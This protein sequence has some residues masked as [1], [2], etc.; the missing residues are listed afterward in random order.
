MKQILM[1]LALLYAV[2]QGAWAQGVNYIYYTVNSDGKTI[3]K[4][5][6][7][8]A[9]NPTVLTSKLISDNTEDRLYDGWY[10]L[11]S[12]F[13]Y[14]ERIVIYGDVKLILKDGCTLTAEQGIRINT[15]AKLTI[16]A[17]SEGDNMGKLVAIE[18]HHDK[19]AIGGN[20][21]YEAGRLVI[22]GG[23]IEATCIKESSKYAAGIGGGYGDGSGMKEITIYG[24]KVTAQGAEGGAGIGGGK[25]N[26]HPGT[27]NIYGGDITAEAGD[28]GAGIG[29]G[30]NRDGWPIIINGGKVYAHSGN[31]GAGIG[32]GF[33][34]SGTSVVING[35]WVQAYG[36][37]G[38]AG[39]GGG[40]GQYYSV[41]DDI[42]YVVSIGFYTNATQKGGHSGAIAIHGG[43]VFAE[44]NNYDWTVSA[45]IGGGIWGDV[46]G[47]ITIDGGEVRVTSKTYEG[48][49]TPAIGAGLNGNCHGDITITGTANVFLYS[50]EENGDE[51][52]APHYLIGLSNYRDKAFDGTLNLSGMRVTRAT[53][54]REEKIVAA[55][56]VSVCKD[57]KSLWMRIMPCDH[58]DL[59]Y[60]YINESGHTAHCKYCEYT[61]N[62][63]HS[64]LAPSTTCEKCGYGEGSTICTLSFP[65]TS[66]A[67]VSG[68][69]TA[70]FQAVQGQIITIPACT[71]VPEGWKFVGWLKQSTAPTSIEAADSETTL[72]QPGD[73]YTVT[74]NEMFF[75]RYR[76]DFVETWMWNES[77]SS[78]SLSI[79]AGS[80]EAISVTPVTVSDRTEIAATDAA[81]GSITATATATYTHGSTTYTFSSTQT[82]VL[83]YSLSLGEDDNTEALTT[84]KGRSMNVTLTG[85]TLYKDGNWNTLCLPFSVGDGDDTDDVTFSGSPLAGA[86]VKELTDASFANGTLT[87]TFTD[88]TG[89][90]AGKPYLIKWDSGTDLGPSDL[91]FT[92]VTLTKDLY[93]DEISTDDSGTTTVTFMGTYKQ[94]SFN[95]DDKSILFLGANNTLYYPQSG[96]SIGAQR[97]YFKL[98]GLS[99]GNIANSAIVLNFGDGETTG[100]IS[101]DNGELRI[102]NDDWYSL[103]GRKLSGKPSVRGIYINNGK[104]VVIK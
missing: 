51:N 91:I 89:I 70:G 42:L 44:G 54:E 59:T 2:A 75:A 46:N 66:T 97:A 81:D 39:I 24:G 1:T 55:N 96:A 95:A 37:S 8:T 101:I 7:G 28:Y 92:G 19:A 82:K 10:V 13:S 86:T 90:E 43:I 69:A 33:L 61:K 49:I 83:S 67:E 31:R 71:Y 73:E 78:A 45:G 57:E 11:N 41:G 72:L 21:N 27:I 88:A 93:E 22:H 74:D 100:I 20:K 29:G 5:E 77:L 17:Q 102:D 25:N 99:V 50:V 36:S 85:R 35:G 40:C 56:R 23:E 63:E 98:S 60:S 104:K 16:Y 34:G 47:P 68:Y 79:K 94:L 3:T 15:D 76:Y 84:Y 87:L 53:T 103:D 4:H 12:S 80:D 58:S 6:D 65:Q 30:Q 14:P 9:S 38:G 48:D 62:E 52:V 18:T 64:I 26:N 32:G